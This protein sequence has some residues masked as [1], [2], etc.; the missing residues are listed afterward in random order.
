LR[1]QA[2]LKGEAPV[3][4]LIAAAASALIAL[5]GGV[6]PAGAAEPR[7]A[8]GARTLQAEGLELLEAG[9]AAEALPKLEAAYKLA[10]T[11]QTTFSLG[12]AHEKLGNL[13]E[14]LE[15]FVRFLREAKHLPPMA[16]A[17][18]EARR[19]ALRARIASLSVTG[20]AGGTV[21]VDGRAAGTLPLAQ[22][23]V[24]TAGQHEIALERDGVRLHQQ[25]IEAQAG[26]TTS[27]ALVAREPAPR[28]SFEPP[29]PPAPSLVA[30]AEVEP[31]PRRPALAERGRREDWK[32]PAAWTTAGLGA[33][34][35][36]FGAFNQARA[37]S[38]YQAFNAIAD[39]P[40]TADQMCHKPAVMAGGPRCAERLAAGDRARRL[41][42]VGFVAGGALA[43][44]SV[45]LFY[46]SATAR[47]PSRQASW[48]CGPSAGAG[49]GC[50]GRF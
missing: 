37:G 42:L 13:A 30:E 38:E 1:D 4:T 8:S 23:V 22:P 44:T 32:T 50:G 9:R 46:L 14:A 21:L 3:R 24:V 18:A 31:A 47:E 10:P 20:P 36:V 12:R 33:A 29:A 43:V 15:C 35:L 2:V 19:D 27:V 28:E 40:L 49:V 26:T 41:A 11:P 5:A 7:G 16:R 6:S 45:V 34:G 25:V 17:D 39:A 48:S